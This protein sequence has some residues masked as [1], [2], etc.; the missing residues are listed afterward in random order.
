VAQS[1]AR[2]IAL[3]ALRRWRKKRAFAD[4]VIGR[5][6]A[7]SQ[8]QSADRAFAMDLFYG[9]LRN[10]TLLDFWISLLRRERLESDLRDLLRLG[11][12]Q[13]LLAQVQEHAAVYES[14]EL[15]S[16]PQR[17]IV[18]ALLRSA[19]RR[20]NELLTNAQNQPL[21]VR[22]SHPRFLIDRWNQQFGNT[23][24]EELCEWNNAP[25]PI[26]ARINGL[27]IDRQTFLERYRTA[28]T[29]SE[30]ENFVEL[31]LAANALEA[32]DCYVQ[33]PST[34]LACELLAPNPGQNILDACAAP[35]GKTSYIAELMKNEGSLVACDRDPQRIQLLSENLSRLGVQN[36]NIVQ[37]D[38]TRAE[39]KPDSIGEAAF[40]RILV[41]APCSNTGVIRR[42]VDVRWRLKS[43]EFRV[44]QSRQ[45]EIVRAVAPL[46]KP[47]GVLVY[48]TCSLEREENED[49]VQQLVDTLSM[50]RLE[51]ER[52]SLPFIDHFDGAYV[53]RFR[54]QS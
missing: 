5:A 53:A 39:R 47:G 27:K 18:N 8:L 49:V 15:A 46:L 30:L 3:A 21:E 23:A 2:G 43:E 16:K 9:V 31:P 33:D 26:Y 10:L 35:G 52:K 28:R 20:A 51:Q 44:M 45:V 42:R 4:V 17:S 11:V 37:H 48:S 36:A 34:A 38:W 41:D 13:L 7:T 12:Y 14:V 40:D 50:L 29:V 22:A 19:Q 25:P 24:T 6:L 32:G 1:S 54:R